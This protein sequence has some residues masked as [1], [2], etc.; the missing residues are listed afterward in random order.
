[1][2]IER[3][4]RR[5][6]AVTTFG[7]G[8]IYDFGSE[9]FVAMDTTEWKRGDLDIRLP[10]LERFLGTE[11]FRSPPIPAN[12]RK[13]PFSRFP[14]WMFC[15]NCR[16]MVNFIARDEEIG[17]KPICKNSKCQGRVHLVPM[18]FI[19]VCESGHM[20]DIQWDYW[21]HINANNKCK[22]KKLM[23]KSDP[24]RG[25]GMESLIISCIDC[26]A[27]NDL[28]ELIPTYS[29]YIK[30][31]DGKQ[32]WK[33][34]GANCD[35]EPRVVQKNAAQV[36]FPMITDA[37]DIRVS[38]AGSSKKEVY[39]MIRHHPAWDIIKRAMSTT[40]LSFEDKFI[41]EYVRQILEDPGIKD[42]GIERSD[43]LDS[44][45]NVE[46]DHDDDFTHE[47][48][49]RSEEWRVFL[50]PPQYERND[51][52]IADKVDLTTLDLKI[53]DDEKSIW[54]EFKKIIS[55]VTLAR[56]LRIV[57]AFTG[58]TRVNPEPDNKIS[59]SLDISS[60]W[61]PATEIYGEGVFIAFNLKVLEKWERYLPSDL[62]SGM[63]EA[64]ENCTLDFLP[65]VTPRF[66]ML[67]T[68]SHLLIRQLCFECGYSS[69]SLSERIYSDDSMAGILIYTAEA[70]SEGA[71]G[72]LVREG[73]PE[74]FYNTFKTALLRSKW[75]SNDPICME[76]KNQGMQ[77]LNQSSC[78]A[79]S[80]VAE[81]SCEYANTLLSRSVLY[82]DINR[83][84]V[85]FFSKI[86]RL[87]EERM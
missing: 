38:S 61:L 23:F 83:P 65:Q 15:P 81:T 34:S 8:S 41:S 70:D 4:I 60:N 87:I 45:S 35:Q 75:C 28:G 44:F 14:S 29:K 37:I 50:E 53:N 43:I 55:V 57:K 10:R 84:D 73:K 30:S 17:K 48:D 42:R 1:M 77:G 47:E 69:S 19:S 46:G 86:V 5:S 74:R 16:H 9:S 51:Q 59:P 85:G 13:V 63:Y 52:F 67:H 2:S 71:L 54:D 27:E 76:M 78:H 18:R 33:R 64:R 26:N 56:K 3:K 40:G 36:F 39:A 25:A 68:F 62:L 11:G 49:L 66:F 31:C 24:K 22:S 21:A 12:N 20:S 79:C 6:Q 32:P 80:L 72:G 58:F 7:V 82:G